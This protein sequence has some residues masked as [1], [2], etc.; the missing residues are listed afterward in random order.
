MLKKKK[1]V[2][3]YVINNKIPKTLIISKMVIQKHFL[4]GKFIKKY[5]RLYVH[6][7]L[8][9]PCKINDLVE[10]VQ[11]RPYSKLKTWVLTKIIK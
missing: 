4:Y 11:S 5:S 1:I 3:G 10:V 8:N 9:V 6:N 2:R 7:S